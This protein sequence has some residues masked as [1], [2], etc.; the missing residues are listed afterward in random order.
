V[1]KFTSD[2]T[3][4]F[5]VGGY[6]VSGG[7]ADTRNPRQAADV[8][9]HAPTGE[10][11]VAD[12]YGNRRV[13]VIDAATGAFERQWGAFGN[14]PVDEIPVGLASPPPVPPDP[15][16]Q[17]ETEGPGPDQFGIVHGIGVSDDGLVYVA[18]RGN[19][20]IQVFTVDGE[21]VTQAFVNRTGPSPTGVARVEFSGDPEQRFLFA[22]D[23][24][25]GRIWILDRETLETVGEIGAPGAEPGQFAALHHIAVDSR[26]TVFTAE[27]GGNRRVQ[28][29]VVTGQ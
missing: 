3:F 26:N 13:W 2:G 29:F 8:S 16:A 12:G 24:G 5:Q 22:N 21:Y 4:L 6:G 9:V 11:F 7:N 17:L 18:D 14:A 25:N 19:R 20:R 1:L 15:D 28:K 10:A 27:V 23:F